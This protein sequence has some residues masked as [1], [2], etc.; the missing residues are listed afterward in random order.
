MP[1]PAANCPLVYLLFALKC[2]LSILNIG[3]V[4]VRLVEMMEVGAKWFQYTNLTKVFRSLEPKVP[5][6][7]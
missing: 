2:V 6:Q 5:I 3:Y 1:N 7:Q 4:L